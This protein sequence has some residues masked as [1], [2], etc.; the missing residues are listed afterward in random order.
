MSAAR[1]KTR[2]QKHLSIPI[3]AAAGFLRCCDDGTAG[4]PR[5]MRRGGAGRDAAHR[6]DRP[7]PGRAAR[8]ERPGNEPGATHSAVTGDGG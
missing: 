4:A 7:R 3:I 8:A 1:I 6:P 5:P 2:K